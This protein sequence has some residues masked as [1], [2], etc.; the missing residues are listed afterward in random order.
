MAQQLRSVGI[1][2]GTFHPIHKGHVMMARI[3]MQELDLKKVLFLPDGMPPHKSIGAVT[4]QQRLEMTRLAIEGEEGFVVTAR[5]IERQGYTYTVDTMRQLTQEYPNERFVQII[6]ADT[7]LEL[8]NWKDFD[9]IAQM[10]AFF[11]VPRQGTDCTRVKAYAKQLALR[12]GASVTF[13][14]RKSVDISSTRL[15]AMIEKGE[16]WETYIPEKT[17]AYIRENRLY[18]TREENR[19]DAIA[20]SVRKR[21]PL[22][23]WH[24]TLGVVETAQALARR[25]GADEERVRLAA[26]LHDCAKAYNGKEAEACMANYNVELD[27]FARNA[28]KLWHGPLGAAI[29]RHEYGVHDEEILNAVRVHTIGA[30]HMTML[31]KIVK[32]ADLI[33]PGRT[34]E[35]V[36]ELRALAQEDLDAALLAAMR[37]TMGYLDGNADKMHPDSLAAM[38]TLA[39]EIQRRNK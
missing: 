38:Q 15:R 8:E 3:A 2:G 24:H 25:F 4:P 34:Y 22:K 36:E 12:Y 6:G 27:D 28:P 23:R 19:F 18:M 26:L 1:L 30:P 16:D 5:E 11:A 39:D 32:L 9:K 35:G 37:Q 31:E 29:A 13:A 33:E 10:C 21:L 17:A 7:L 14:G 20:N